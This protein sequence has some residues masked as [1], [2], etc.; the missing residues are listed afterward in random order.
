VKREDATLDR[1][2]RVFRRKGDEGQVTQLIA[3]FASGN[4]EFA[5]SLAKVIVAAAPYKDRLGSVPDRLTCTPENHLFGADGTDLG[6]VDLRF[7]DEAAEFSLLVELKLHSGYGWRQLERYRDALQDLPEGR[8]ALLAV[9]S[10]FPRYGE[11]EILNDPRWLGSVRWSNV[12]DELVKVQHADEAAGDLWRALLA[13]MREQGDFG[14]MDVEP[15]DIRGWSRWKSGHNTL[16]ALMEAIQEPALE[17]VRRQLAEAKGVEPSEE[18]AKYLTYKDRLVYPWEASIH[19]EMAVPAANKGERIRIQVAGGRAVPVFTAEAR[20]EDARL[21][22][23]TQP[24]LIEA[25]RVLREE[26]FDDPGHS[27]GSYWSRPHPPEEWLD[28]GTGIHDAMLTIV[29]SDVGAI[30]KSGIL[31]ALPPSEPGA[32]T[33][34][35][36]EDEQE[37]ASQ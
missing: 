25:T 19:L 14:L 27:Y 30:V 5:G 21:L 37:L 10:H 35:P 6:Y 11:D 29:E 28:K 18:L 17:I 22:M 13:L 23:R 15:A 24:A 20:H 32:K 8:S 7:E 36:P 9:T 31:D 26:G 33:E 3:A 12:Y 4:P 1:I 16:I 34:I 2:L